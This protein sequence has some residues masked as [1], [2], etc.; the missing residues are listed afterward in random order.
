M[1]PTQTILGRVASADVVKT[2]REWLDKNRNGTR[3]GLAL[4]LC[5]V[6]G[7]RD[8]KGKPR[9]AGVYKAL[10]TLESRGLWTLPEPQSSG[11]R[12]WTPR[13]LDEPVPAPRG[14]PG[15]VEDV[16]SL[17]LV[18]VQRGD[19]EGLRTWNELVETEHPLSPRLVG[20]QLRYLI[21]SEH[22]WLGAIGF[23]SCALRSN[24]RDG[25]LGWDEPTRATYQERLVGL[26]RFLIRPQVRCG[27]LASRA[28]SLC[29]K[30]LP[31]DYQERY[32]I[33]PWLVETFVDREQFAGTCFQAANWSRIGVTKGRGRSAP[34]SQPVT[35]S[36][37]IYLYPL[38]KNWRRAIGL[39]APGQE[40]RPMPVEEALDTERWVEQEFGGVDLGHK[41]R[42]RRLVEIVSAK[43]SNPAATYPE[44]FGGNRHE[45]KTL[46]RFMAKEEVT[47]RSILAGHRQCTVRRMK[48]RKRVLIVQDTT[49]LNFS[50]RL[51]CNGLG[52]IGTNQ[53]GAK[54]P[55]LK[56]HSALAIGEDG[57]PLGVLS[58][59]VYP[60]KA[61]DKQPQNRPIE[62]KESYRWLRIFEEA[63]E[64]APS[65][66]HT[67]LVAV[68]DRESDIFELFDLRR[69]NPSV[70][71]LVR[72]KHNRC[73]TDHKLKLFD[74]LGDLPVE[75]RAEIEVPRQREKKGKPSKPGRPALPA[76]TAQVELRWDKVTIAAPQAAQ[77]R[78]LP[79]VQLYALLVV[80][81]DPPEGAKRVRWVLLTTLPIPSR[82]QALRCLRHYTSRWRIEEWHRVLKSDCGV[83]AHQ[84]HT[85]ERLAKAAAIDAVIAW[86]AMLLTLLAREAPDLPAGLVFSPWECKVLEVF[87]PILAPETIEEKK[88]GP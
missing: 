27:N 9:A 45:L 69:R 50:E 51:H 14:V 57:L 86:R 54:S 20:R 15:R 31:I 33:E 71:L 61:G 65:L 59:D 80:E 52:V 26:T 84:H 63:A 22:G 29:L 16:Q 19:D 2:V 23:G 10:R 49:D 18:C 41:D 21:G 66:E 82:K 60:P 83:Q 38:K 88:R 53:T 4:H 43:A 42:D 76:R 58:T 6:L 30:R 37:D 44:C 85:A 78:D 73:L 1:E 3:H 56:M 46:Y 5:E 67:E 28:L 70:H 13:C 39:P 8:P 11:A 79:P 12:T 74:H 72:A 7:L 24:V 25:W 32:G 35:S 87:Q 68:G 17:H 77:T 47:P 40:V 36:K 75:A 64:I 48:G 62:E 34:T 81:P 55:G